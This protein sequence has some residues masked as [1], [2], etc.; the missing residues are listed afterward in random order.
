MYTDKRKTKKKLCVLITTNEKM[1]KK[2]EQCEKRKEN[3][4]KTKI[5]TKKTIKLAS[6]FKIEEHVHVTKFFMKYKTHFKKRRLVICQFSI[7]NNH[8]NYQP[9]KQLSN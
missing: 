3:K 6:I 4:S 9:S 1:K 5:K 7:A 8:H 2:N